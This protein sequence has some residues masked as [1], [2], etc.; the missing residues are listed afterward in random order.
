VRLAHQNDK[1]LLGI[2]RGIQVMNV[3]MGGTLILDIPAQVGDAVTHQVE[4]TPKWRKAILHDVEIDSQSRLAEAV[5]AETLPVNSIHHQAVKMVAKSLRVTACAS[6]GVIEGLEDP[7]RRFF[8]GVQ[9]HPEE[10]YFDSPRMQ[11]LFQSFGD[12]MR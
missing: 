11:A 9:W 4:S 12:V 6:D 2:C 10:I 5:G 3:A 7:T 1:P 8:L